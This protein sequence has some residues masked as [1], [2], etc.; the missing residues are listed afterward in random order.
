[1]NDLKNG[2]K[3][4]TTAN[5]EN[6]KNESIKKENRKALKIYIPILLICTVL[7]G[8]VGFFTSTG[9]VQHLG[10]KLGSWLGEF[11]Y[12]IS[13]YC[14]IVAEAISIAASL[15]FYL[16]ARKAANQYHGEEEED[17]EEALYEQADIKTSKS[18][19]A[20]NI[21][22]ILNFLFFG[23]SF[24][25]IDRNCEERLALFMISIA[26]FMLS[27]F[28]EVWLNQLQVDLTKRLN[29]K[30]KG[31][32]YDMKFHKKWEESCDEAEKLTIYKAAY[33]AFQML[34]KMCSTLW[35]L[36]ILGSMV[37][38]YGALPVVVV[39]LIWLT[40]ILTYYREGMRLEH[41]KINE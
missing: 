8:V 36:L 19:I 4:E 15:Y 11:F 22:L 26:V 32:V 25:Q 2:Q 9:D 17:E 5:M 6:E 13:P 1:M 28:A 33:K 37:F 16:S 27:A 23:I 20:A 29:P 12:Q 30:M 35:L 14:L 40:V 41:G 3:T 31:S 34:N 39:T 7:G 10:T 21:G 18:M 38:H 24:S